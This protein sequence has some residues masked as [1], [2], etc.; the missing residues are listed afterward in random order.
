MSLLQ[1]LLI[2]CMMENRIRL[3]Y[4]IYHGYRSIVVFQAQL[5]ESLK[6]CAISSAP[7]ILEVCESLT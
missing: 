6:K 1:A 4:D 2:T 3:V 5:D 7:S